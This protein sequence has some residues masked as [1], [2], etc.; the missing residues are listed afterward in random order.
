MTQNEI[1]QVRSEEE[2]E[3]KRG[4]LVSMTEATMAIGL[5]KAGG[6]DEF[7]EKLCDHG[8]QLADSLMKLNEAWRMD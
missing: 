1:N 7:P 5:V 6:F 4:E 3:N 2:L 8:V